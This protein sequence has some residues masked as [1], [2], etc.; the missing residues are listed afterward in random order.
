MASI[1]RAQGVPLSCIGPSELPSTSGGRVVQLGPTRLLIAGDDT[2]AI[3]DA[4]ALKK[5]EEIEWPDEIIAVLGRPTGA[6]I[7]SKKKIVEVNSSGI[8]TQLFSFEEAPEDGNSNEFG[9]DVALFLK[10]QTLLV[11]I[12][13]VSR[14]LRLSDRKQLDLGNAM[15]NDFFLPSEIEAQ[16]RDILTFIRN[17]SSYLVDIERMKILEMPTGTKLVQTATLVL[18]KIIVQFSSD[19][20]SNIAIF[21]RVSG[22]VTTIASPP[23][24]LDP[25]FG[26]MDDDQIAY[27]P[28]A[29]LLTSLN[30]ISLKNKTVTPSLGNYGRIGRTEGGQYWY[31]L[32]GN[33]IFVWNS[34]LNNLERLNGLPIKGIMA[35][36]PIENGRILVTT[37]TGLFVADLKSKMGTRVSRDPSITVIQR[38]DS[39]RWIIASSS[40]ILAFDSNNDS[41]VAL[42][43]QAGN[44]S[45][46]G[47]ATRD[48][49]FAATEKGVLRFD[50]AQRQ[51]DAFLDENEFRNPFSRAEVAFADEHVFLTPKPK[52]RGQIINVFESGS[53]KHLELPSSFRGRQIG[54]IANGRYFISDNDDLFIFDPKQM[55]L[56]HLKDRAIAGANLIS[57]GPTR[58]VIED[59]GKIEEVVFRVPLEEKVFFNKTN[60]ERLPPQ[61]VPVEIRYRFKHPCVGGLST[62]RPILRIFRSTREESQETPLNFSRFKD[63]K[64][65]WISATAN[66]EFHAPGLWKVEV[67]A[68]VDGQEAVLASDEVT[69]SFSWWDVLTKWWKTALSV[70]ACLYVVSFIALFVLAHYRSWAL[71]ILTDPVWAKIAIWPFFALRH[72]AFAQQWVFA[73]YFE[74]VRQCK[75][76][77][78]LAYLPVLAT[79]TR[80]EEKDASELIGELASHRLVWLHGGPGM[81]KSLIFRKWLRRYFVENEDLSS[82]IKSHGYILI[83]VLVREYSDLPE[84]PDQ[85]SDWFIEVVRRQL[86]SYDM[87]IEDTALLR[88]MLSSGRF[89]LALDGLNEA[90]RDGALAEFVAAYPRVKIITTCQ[91]LP[92]PGFDLWSLPKTIQ[93]LTQG[94]LRLW[95][96]DGERVYVQ[97]KGLGS[98]DYLIS[99][100]DVRLV[101][102][103]A[104]RAP[105]TLGVIRSRIDLYEAVLELATNDAGEKMDLA[106][107]KRIAWQMLIDG[108]RHLSPSDCQTVGDKSIEQLTADGVRILRQL[109]DRYEFR[110]DQMRSFLASLQL[111]RETPSVEAVI[112]QLEGSAVWQ[113]TRR[114]QEELW[115]FVADLIEKDD[116]ST[117]WRAMLTDPMRAWAQTALLARATREEIAST[118]VTQSTG[119]NTVPA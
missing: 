8:Q 38:G 22:A 66:A 47:M 76:S 101:A 24:V 95:L 19:N 37:Q 92:P 18:D 46:V 119:N 75:K 61:E 12:A 13:G 100:Y 31:L 82:A 86:A 28:S 67:V 2:V 65:D 9:S 105:S 48:V 63:D 23:V 69:I 109:A 102:D 96:K 58:Y 59:D 32:F 97:L 115:S 56:D 99:G 55:T 70:L 78:T 85:R 83:P 35:A 26:V 81:G 107:L 42:P 64:G 87:R 60:I 50:I 44:V 29:E 98:T 77:D 53:F 93:D 5:V 20:G 68:T 91:S 15:I 41:A 49:G 36:Q 104:L 108:R 54:R 106:P 62:F 11:Q 79:N 1:A 10:H 94:L 4:S 110:H 30:V 73:P 114:D 17:G 40:Q 14:L 71:R 112:R 103:L 34:A 113:C 51:L 118:A 80:G 39:G 3:F 72:L 57:I 74:N 6:L 52:G 33:G 116:L 84:K 45:F 89:A 7:I 88:A 25:I 117:L 90:D 27:G 111:V 43:H 16:N 21:D